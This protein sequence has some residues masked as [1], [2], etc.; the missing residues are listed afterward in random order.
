MTTSS[1]RTSPTRV[2]ITPG[3]VVLMLLA[4]A[5]SV[6]ITD[7]LVAARRVLSWVVACAVAAA[8]IELVAQWLD[9]W[10]SR[11]VAIILVMI[12]IGAIAAG[13]AFGV[14]NDL[15]REV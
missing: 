6:L 4:I 1:G 13:I 15:D 14:M 9:R 3:T 8:L 2:E 11:V 10:M 5:A 7:I 12:T